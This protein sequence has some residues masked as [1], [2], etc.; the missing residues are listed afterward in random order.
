MKRPTEIRL[1][2]RGARGKP[3]KPPFGI[4][5]WNAEAVDVAVLL[6]APPENHRAIASVA[7]QLPLA[8]SLP[9]GTAVFVLG[10]APSAHAIW[11][12]LGRT[13]PVARAV[14]CTALLVK[15]YVE[16]GA[17]VDEASG[18]DLVWGSAP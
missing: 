12:L 14:R 17:G 8:S 6:D 2:A 1:S 4:A 11:R 16:I 10:A 13:A 15:G 18:S 5:G 9:S 7:E 3:P